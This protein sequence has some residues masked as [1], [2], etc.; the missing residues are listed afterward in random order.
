MSWAFRSGWL[1]FPDRSGWF[2]GID[3]S[4]L[5]PGDEDERAILI[6]AD[7]PELAEVLADELHEQRGWSRRSRRRP[8]PARCQS[9]S[10]I[11]ATQPL[12]G[13]ISAS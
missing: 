9:A 4:L 7:H 5:D 6:R 3:L 10:G 1:G 11:G 8:R 12:V 13:G 2:D